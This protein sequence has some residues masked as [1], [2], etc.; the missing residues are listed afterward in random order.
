[1]KS[2]RTGLNKKLAKNYGL[3]ETMFDVINLLKSSGVK[4]AELLQNF[5]KS[6]F[7][8][9]I[10]DIYLVYSEYE[11]QMTKRVYFK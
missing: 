8:L 10:K 3:A 6:N 11:K 7:G 4:P 1:M 2:L 9:K 5:D